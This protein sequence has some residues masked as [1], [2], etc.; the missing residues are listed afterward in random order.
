M[1]IDE[2]GRTITNIGDNGSSIWT[3]Y[4][5]DHEASGN[6]PAEIYEQCLVPT[7]FEPFAKDLI[8]LCNVQPSDRLLDVACGTG[9]V[10]RLAIDYID[11]S[12]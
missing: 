12:I 1:N 8:Q 11:S 9:I 10:S 2:K 6:T 5:I 7:M 3:K 4:C